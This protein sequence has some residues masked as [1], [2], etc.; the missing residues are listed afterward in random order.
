MVISFLNQKGGVG[1]STTTSNLMAYFTKQGKKVLGID[2][3]AQG[4]LSKLC[5]AKTQ[6]KKT[7]LELLLEKGTIQEC[8][9]TTKYGDL[10]PADIQLQ[11]A[12]MQLVA[13]PMFYFRLKEILQPVEKDYDYILIDCPPAVNLI[14]TTALVAT[15]Y[16]IIPTE[17]E[18]L[19]LEGVKELS[20][21]IKAVQ[22][23]LNSKLQVM[24]MLYVRFNA[25]RK[26]SKDLDEYMQEKAKEKFGASILPIKIRNTVD[27]PNSQAR[28]QSIFE[29]K[30][31]S[32]VA[33]D[34][35]ELGE[36][37]NNKTKIGGKNK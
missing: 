29:Y 19:S 18:Y 26:L 6:N 8:I 32:G 33:E 37:I 31:N 20:E 30:P 1:K 23:R 14:T 24:G 35:K 12:Q 11:V 13:N 21:T 15:D 28:L 10:I 25:R 5:S 34:Y 22:S 36:Y 17:V 2:I 3:D 27:I 4:N 9:Q 16:V 7:I